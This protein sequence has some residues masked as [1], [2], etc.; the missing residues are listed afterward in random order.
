[1]ER[2]L[3]QQKKT[4]ASHSRKPMARTAPD[5]VSEVTNFSKKH[6]EKLDKRGSDFV[7]L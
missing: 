3:W 1:M 6:P 5:K 7:S 2:I 4:A